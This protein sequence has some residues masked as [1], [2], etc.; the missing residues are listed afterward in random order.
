MQDFAPM[1]IKA[2]SGW[3]KF[4]QKIAFLHLYQETYPMLQID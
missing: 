3:I 4:S 2:I 1:T